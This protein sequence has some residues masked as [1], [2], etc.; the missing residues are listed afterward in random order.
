MSSSFQG[1][2]RVAR[3]CAYSCLHHVDRLC[4]TVQDFFYNASSDGL[5]ST[6]CAKRGQAEFYASLQRPR[7]TENAR[8]YGSRP[9]E[10]YSRSRNGEMEE[11]EREKRKFLEAQKENCFSESDFKAPA[12]IIGKNLMRTMLLLIHMLVA[13]SVRLDPGHGSFVCSACFRS[14]TSIGFI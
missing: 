5:L 7:N 1:H 2:I 3:P 4:G 14:C 13:D 10:S 8:S 12:R 6:L 9:Y 11:I